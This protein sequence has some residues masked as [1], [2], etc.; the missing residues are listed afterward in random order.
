MITSM[1]VPAD[2]MS[3]LERIMAVLQGKAPDRVPCVPLIL[4]HAARVLGVSI[5]EYNRIG[6][7]MGKAHIAAWEK[8]GHDMPL[9]FSTT[10]TLAEAM[11]TRLYFPED[12]AP[13]VE[14]PVVQFPKDTARVRVAD[15]RT[16]GRLPVYLEAAEICIGELGDRVPVGI[17][18]AAPFTTAAAL[19]G[20]EELIRE[21]YKNPGLVDRLMDLALASALNMLEAVVRVGAVPVLV[22]PVG[23]ASLISPVAFRKFV[24][25]RLKQLVERAHGLG[26]PICLHICGK[27]GP[28]MDLMADTGADI[29]S[30]DRVDLGEVS[31]RVGDR[32]CLLGNVTPTETLLQGRPEKV[33]EE[34]REIISKTIGNPRGFILSSGCEVPINTPPENLEALVKAARLFG[35]RQER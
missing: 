33:M 32:C 34:A 31:R 26:S 12:D 25:P 3:G 8:Y 1:G 17:I 15:P 10:S 20:T 27:T 9:M 19:R 2:T 24:Q 23:S 5:S 21:T 7:V 13:W 14:T 16:D 22:E 28:V 18:F 35:R 4:N 30:L 6:K 29:L 11:G